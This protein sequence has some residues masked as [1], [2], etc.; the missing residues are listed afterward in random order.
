MS[1]QKPVHS[2]IIYNSKKWKQPKCQ[3]TNEH[4][5]VVQPYNG[6]LFDNVKELSIGVYCK[7]DR[8]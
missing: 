3:S 6:I 1:T 4:I 2:S 7:M 5:N 8:P